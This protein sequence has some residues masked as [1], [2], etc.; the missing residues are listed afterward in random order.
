MTTEDAEIAEIARQAG[1]EVPF[2]RPAEL[3]SDTAPGIA[4]VMHALDALPET[5]ELV[6]LQPTSPLRNAAHIDAAIAMAHEH[7]ASSVVSVRG[8]EEPPAHMFQRGEDGTLLPFAP[9]E[10]A[11]RRQDL[12]ELFLL[13][14][15]IY[16]ARADWLREGQRLVAPE[17]LAFVMDAASSVDI[18]TELDW[19]LAELLL[20]E[21]T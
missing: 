9:D 21:R 20:S 2:L 19:R 11:A 16:Y 17:T 18:D 10:A 13:N 3:A 8:V 6:L 14:G 12:R 7:R 4:P 5:S 1:A 15:A